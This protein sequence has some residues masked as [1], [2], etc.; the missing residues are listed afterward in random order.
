MDPVVI[1]GICFYVDS[2]PEGGYIMRATTT[3]E[4][5]RRIAREFAKYASLRITN[6]GESAPNIF[7]I[8]VGSEDMGRRLADMVNSFNRKN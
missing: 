2:R 1:K 5:K 4:S 8:V 3:S 6:N 7:E